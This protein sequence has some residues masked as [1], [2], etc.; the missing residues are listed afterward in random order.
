M[1]TIYD[2]TY[3]LKISI[4]HNFVIFIVQLICKLNADKYWLLEQNQFERVAMTLIIIFYTF[5]C[6]VVSVFNVG[7]YIKIFL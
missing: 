7:Y 3:Q 5:G 2:N 6:E 1:S 4:S